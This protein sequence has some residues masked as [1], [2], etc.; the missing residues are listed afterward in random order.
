[1]EK[2]ASAKGIQF[3]EDE[4]LRKIEA[5]P[6]LWKRLSLLVPKA[7]VEPARPSRGAGF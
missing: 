5:F 3:G 7:G 4:Y 2:V 1:M 6:I